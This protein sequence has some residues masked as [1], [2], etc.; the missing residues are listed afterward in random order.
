MLSQKT[1]S[2]VGKFFSDL[3]CGW[4][5]MASKADFGVKKLPPFYE[6]CPAYVNVVTMKFP[7]AVY[8]EST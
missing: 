4:H 2:L 1:F 5:N 7:N 8:Y 3:I 6:L